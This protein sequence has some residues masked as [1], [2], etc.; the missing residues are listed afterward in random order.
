MNIENNKIT[1][2]TIISNTFNNYFIECVES[3]KQSLPLVNNDYISNIN[4]PS[5][6]FMLNPCTPDEVEKILLRLKNNNFHSQIPTRI[7]KYYSPY[8]SSILCDLYNRCFENFT[9]PN[10]LK[11]ARIQPV[12]KSGSIAEVSNFRS[13]SILSLISKILEKLVYNRL[14][15][16]IELSDGF[17]DVQFGFLKNR[18]IEKAVLTFLTD[19]ESYKRKNLSCVA[20]FLDYSKAFDTVDHNILLQKLEKYG[21]RGGAPSL[22]SILPL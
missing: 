8:M 22:F 19:I 3:L 14:Y 12:H 18:G 1:N 9:F 17:S 13:I 16:F 21:I 2:P 11:V 15:S 6:S 7:L 20:C 10:I 4:S 5:S